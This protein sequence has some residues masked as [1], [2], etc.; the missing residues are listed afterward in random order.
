M[1][2]AHAAG[3]TGSVRKSTAAMFSDLVVVFDEETKTWKI[4]GPEPRRAGV[5]AYPAGGSHGI[6]TMG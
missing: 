5:P 3:W 2:R 4:T 1:K 6:V